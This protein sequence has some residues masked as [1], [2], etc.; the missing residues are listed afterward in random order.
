MARTPKV[1]IDAFFRKPAVVAGLRLQPFTAAHFMALERM[2]NPLAEEAAKG[3]MTG[4]QILRALAILST[5]A[6]T[7]LDMTDAEQE[8]AVK[9]IAART[10]V[11]DLIGI[12]Q[13]LTLHVHSYFGTLPERYQELDGG[14]DRPFV[15]PTAKRGRAGSPRNLRRQP[16]AT[17]R[18]SAVS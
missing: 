9:A 18:R 5:P 16:A 14:T 1:V 4:E 17:R 6:G 13:A 15:K 3:T 12:S 11:P 8:A 7:V 10:Q 2:K